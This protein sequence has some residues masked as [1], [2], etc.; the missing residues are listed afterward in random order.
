MNKRRLTGLLLLSF[1]LT[2][3]LGLFACAKDNKSEQSASVGIS[4]TEISYGSSDHGSY[5]HSSS[6]DGSASYAVSD[7]YDQSA[8]ASGVSSASGGSSSNGGSSSSGDPS[9]SGDPPSPPLADTYP[10][11]FYNGESL[12]CEKAVEKGSEIAFPVDWLAENEFI[13][14]W[15]LDDRG[16]IVTEAIAT[17]KADYYA[18]VGGI[19]DGQIKISY[20]YE[21]E[22]DGVKFSLRDLGKEVDIHSDIQKRYLD[23]VGDSENYDIITTYVDGKSEN[24]IPAPVTLEF[25]A[26]CPYEVDHYEV[27]ISENEDMSY[28]YSFE[29]TSSSVSVYNLKVGTVYYWNV[30]SYGSERETASGT[31]AFTTD[32]VLPRNVFVEGI[33]NF[34]DLGG[35]ISEKSAIKQGLVFRCGRT[36]EVDRG[37]AEEILVKNFGIKTEIDLRQ[38]SETYYLDNSPIGGS[39]AYYNFPMTYDGNVLTDNFEQINNVFAVL[40]KEENYPLLFHCSIGTDRTGMVA[41]LIRALL[42]AD[43]KTLCVDYVWSAFGNINGTRSSS[44]IKDY[45]A[46]INTASG[47]TLKERTYNYLAANGV[48]RSY[49]DDM[50]GILSFSCVNGVHCEKDYIT[51]E[52]T[53]TEDGVRT[54]RCGYCGA[55]YKS[56]TLGALGH[57]DENNDG[58]CDRC[59]HAVV[60]A[61]FY[62]Q[63]GELISSAVYISGE[64]VSFP[65]EGFSETVKVVGWKTAGSE[66]VIVEATAT[67]STA[68]YAVE[69]TIYD[70]TVVYTADFDISESFDYVLGADSVGNGFDATKLIK[71]ES[72]ED[73]ENYV[74]EDGKIVFNNESVRAI[75][76]G[77]HLL[78]LE[79]TEEIYRIKIAV[80]TKI[81]RN[82]TDLNYI[83]AN[84]NDA[85]F[86]TGYYI[87]G[88]DIDGAEQGVVNELSLWCGDN[89]ETSGFRGVFDGRG[90]V[91]YNLKLKY[92][93]FFYGVGNNAV[94]KNFALIDPVQMGVSD[95]VLA[96]GVHH[97]TIENVVVRADSKYVLGSTW[98]HTVVRNCLFVIEK[99]SAVVGTAGNWGNRQTTL[100]N[101]SIVVGNPSE[102]TL[103]NGAESFAGLIA[104]HYQTGDYETFKTLN[105]IKEYTNTSAMLV[106][107]GVEDHFI[108]RNAEYVSYY[109]GDIYFDGKRIIA[110]TVRLS[111]P[112]TEIPIGESMVLSA[113][114]SV[115]ELVEDIEGVAIDELSGLL[116]VGESV[117]VGSVITV[118]ANSL[119]R[120]DYY[121][122]L[123]VT[124]TVKP[125]DL[126][127][128]GV[129][130]IELGT[131]IEIPE[132][133]ESIIAIKTSSGSKMTL[134]TA[135]KIT[136][137]E[138]K[139]AA[140]VD[141]G[142]NV[143][144]TLYTAV[145]AYS[146]RAAFITKIIRNV[147]D[148]KAI[149]AYGKANRSSHTG[150]YILGNDIDG[151]DQDSFNAL[152]Y[153]MPD[154][155]GYTTLGFR[156]IFDGRGHV[157]KNLKLAEGMLFWGIGNEG[158]VK[159]FALIDPVQLQ[160]RDY[161]L[162]RNLTHGT[163]SNVIVKAQSK[164]AILFT[165]CGAIIENCVF[166][167]ETNG[168]SIIGQKD[169]AFGG[170]IHTPTVIRNTA[171]VVKSNSGTLSAIAGTDYKSSGASYEDYEAANGIRDYD[172][173]SAMLTALGGGNYIEGWNSSYISFSDGHLKLNE[174]VIV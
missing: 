91:L 13:T 73:F 111:A 114:E 7:S 77:D 167:L 146:V 50:I 92:G 37:S 115:F 135:D 52:P 164:N 29:T 41:F 4:D 96:S 163:V 54:Y 72:E 148:L 70:N 56:E 126:T 22:R 28:A 138:L 86:A 66:D 21:G 170:A 161:A 71:I 35:K 98:R 151:A 11:A 121:E 42:G 69:K 157:L 169:D 82:V 44:V 83:G 19:Y 109:D 87:L 18:I 2:L 104:T 97:A 153:D 75:P 17:A 159:N 172:S 46:K 10:I 160:A 123:T 168:T 47:S 3:T 112:S 24:S 99:G 128:S 5:D 80:V 43:E 63:N 154:H 129:Y 144:I 131:T 34:R 79:T 38:K 58:I 145:K 48:E 95:Y 1:L 139:A 132:I 110:F 130:D 122:E 68:Y 33:T 40:S 147:D 136:S 174:T 117:P 93:Y 26:D 106:D 39:V 57:T 12:I 45:I 16:E 62:T 103:G 127:D 23:A 84:K 9:G 173:V 137:E 101:L 61:E 36:E 113:T 25:S 14:G 102:G 100:K 6:S 107:L 134:G 74:V 108:E 120:A 166:I 125:V 141:C 150:Y 124:V 171:V 90:H 89:F 88:N 55:S 51:T 67:V 162:T 140:G 133:S 60:K 116:T 118:R 30:V 105:D 76:V 119:I 158:V 49:M 165:D 27:L 8:S 143:A 142:E 59:G 20:G 152:S 53:C 64:D 78:E 31:A 32:S 65:T 155:D 15:R 81:I 156:G 85:A 149:A 94:I